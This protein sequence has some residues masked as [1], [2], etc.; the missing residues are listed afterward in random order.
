M[1]S[2]NDKTHSQALLSAAFGELSRDQPERY[3]AIRELISE[4]VRLFDETDNYF[5]ERNPRSDGWWVGIPTVAKVWIG[6][7]G[8]DIEVLNSEGKF[9]SGAEV[10][11]D[12]VSR[13][14]SGKDIDD[15][16]HPIPGEP[17]KRKSAH[18]VVVECIISAL[19]MEVADEG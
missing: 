4:V 8:A 12:P 10:V 19:R 6:I 16:F 5:Q 17:R 1:L 7:H 11:Y 18:A 13:Q 9:V 2:E 3:E 14:M 15:F